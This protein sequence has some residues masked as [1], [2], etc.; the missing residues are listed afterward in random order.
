MKTQ[1]RDTRPEMERIHLALLRGTSPAQRYASVRNWSETAAYASLYGSDALLRARQPALV[2]RTDA[3]RAV[4][5]VQRQYG[6]A[7]AAAFAAAVLPRQA[8]QLERFDLSVVL[9]RVLDAL[10]Q[11]GA[12]YALI[13]QLACAIQGL[14][15]AIFGC[16]VLTDLRAEDLAA[17]VAAARTDFLVQDLARGSASRQRQACGLLHLASLVQTTLLVTDGRP[18]D[19]TV[20]RRACALSLTEGGGPWRVAT[21]E[22]VVLLAL[23]DRR[24]DVPHDD[25]RWKD[26]LGVLKMQSQELDLADL[27]QQAEAL[28]VGTLLAQA[29]EDA[30]LA[31]PTMANQQAYTGIQRDETGAR[32]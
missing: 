19:E 1:S 2:P 31:G 4:R 23:A 20:L 3:E 21:P 13:G 9:V 6:A 14:P 11:L 27:S 7:L 30:G 12:R 24:D 29:L 17:F 16:E 8:W 25:D 10:T 15:R 5:F 18:F 26:L 22:D 28:Q 32:R